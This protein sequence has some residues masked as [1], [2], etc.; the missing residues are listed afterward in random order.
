MRGQETGLEQWFSTGGSK[1]PIFK[2]I[3][4]TVHSSTV[5]ELQ[6]S[7]RSENKFMVGGHHSRK[8]YIKR[9]KALERLR[10]NALERLRSCML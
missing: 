2:N 4:I 6:L 7:S 9:V 10:T 5:A 8:N 3:Y 1:A